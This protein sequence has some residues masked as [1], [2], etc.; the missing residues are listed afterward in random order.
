MSQKAEDN[1]RLSVQSD[2]N[3]VRGACD[4]ISTLIVEAE[5]STWEGMDA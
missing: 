1:K 2:M 4:V 3:A 5:D